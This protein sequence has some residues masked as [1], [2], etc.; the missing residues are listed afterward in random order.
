[1]PGAEKTATAKAS[2]RRSGAVAAAERS[3]GE[4]AR[5]FDG[6]RGRRPGRQRNPR[7]GP[8][9][10]RACGEPDPK[11]RQNFTDPESCIAKASARGFRQTHS[12]RAAVD[13]QSRPIAAADVSA[14]A[15]DA[16]RLENAIAGARRNAGLRP[17]AVPA[18]A[19]CADEEAFKNLEDARIDACAARGRESRRPAPGSDKPARRRTAARLRGREGKKPY[20]TRKHV[21]EPP[22]G[23]IKHATGFARFS[24]RGLEKVRGEWGPACLAPDVRRLH[25]GANARAGRKVADSKPLP[26]PARS[27]GARDGR[28]GPESRFRQ[29]PGR[30]IGDCEAPAG[31]QSRSRQTPGRV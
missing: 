9:Y 22:F 26:A 14:G 27:T 13:G 1:M 11:A 5:R 4:K 15:S 30:Q 7:G 28:P 3:L 8:P 16:D 21:A 18:G 23:W 31:P 10:R 6:G 19:G 20:A 12:A 17:G 25:A 2:R 24:V 29:H